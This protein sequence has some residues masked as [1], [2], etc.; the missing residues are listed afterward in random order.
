MKKHSL[1]SR[2]MTHIH[3]WLKKETVL[4]PAIPL[5][6]LSGGLPT[7]E[8]AFSPFYC[9]SSHFIQSQEKMVLFHLSCCVFL[10]SHEYIFSV[11]CFQFLLVIFSYLIQGGIWNTQAPLS[12]I[13][14]LA[15]SLATV[16]E[17]GFPSLPAPHIQT[18]HFTFT[19]IRTK[20]PPHVRQELIH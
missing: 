4:F 9:T 15:L 6:H 12:H 2:K 3:T 10:S 20:K 13:V 16:I 5:C 14:S 11:K 19:Y 17:C 18:M 7:S 8:P 1:H